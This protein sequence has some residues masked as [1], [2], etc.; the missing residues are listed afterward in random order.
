MSFIIGEDY[1]IIMFR[2]DKSHAH[3][4]GFEFYL[5]AVRIIRIC[6]CVWFTLSDEQ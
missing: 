3:A 6:E 4:N 1:D 5:I 2:I